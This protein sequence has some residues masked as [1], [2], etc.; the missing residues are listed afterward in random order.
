MDQAFEAFDFAWSDACRAYA[1][2]RRQAQALTLELL[3]RVARG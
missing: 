1:E 3:R 2:L